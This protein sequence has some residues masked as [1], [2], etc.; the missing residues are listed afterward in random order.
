MDRAKAQK[1]AAA[2]KSACIFLNIDQKF[3]PFLGVVDGL[4][5]KFAE[6]KESSASLAKRKEAFVVHPHTMTRY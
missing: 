1:K 5:V 4:M 2:Q 3:H 6:P